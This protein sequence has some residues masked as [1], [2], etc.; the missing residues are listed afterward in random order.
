M[1]LTHCARCFTR[2]STHP[3]TSMRDTVFTLWVKHR[4]E[5]M[6]QNS[7]HILNWHW[8]LKL[9]AICLLKTGNKTGT[10]SVLS[11]EQDCSLSDKLPQQSS[12]PYLKPKQKVK[13]LAGSK[14]SG[15]LR[16][17]WP[18]R[19]R[20]VAKWYLCY[21]NGWRCKQLKRLFLPREKSLHQNQ[22]FNS[23]NDF[24]NHE[25]NISEDPTEKH[26]YLI[27]HLL[28]TSPFVWTLG[29]VSFSQKTPF[30]KREGACLVGA[31]ETFLL[32]RKT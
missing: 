12:L 28:Q 9:D 8:G 14:G 30:H 29:Q 24:Q 6:C 22:N 11:T 1:C 4:R 23:R 20:K 32:K 7:F 13:V 3:F 10:S 21:G 19:N 31:V 17:P 5:A 25:F 26:N 27:L 2:I 15:S 18:K 16:D